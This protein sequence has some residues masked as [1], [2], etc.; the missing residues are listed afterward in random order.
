MSVTKGIQIQAVGI[1]INPINPNLPSPSC[2]EF[3]LRIQ[4]HRRRLLSLHQLMY[5]E[6][7][8]IPTEMF[9]ISLH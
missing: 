1:P 5:A 9:G 6:A 4:E 7:I 3:Y 2:E 8:S